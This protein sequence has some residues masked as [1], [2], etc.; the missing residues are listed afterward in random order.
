[1]KKLT[2]ALMMTIA[3]IPSQVL[4]F[5]LPKIPGVPILGGGGAAVDIEGFMTKASATNKLF[6]ESALTL[7]MAIGDKKQLILKKKMPS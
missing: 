6:Q 5:G 1:M 3:I 4:A 2:L 7:A